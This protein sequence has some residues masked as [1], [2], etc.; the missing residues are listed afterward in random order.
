[1]LHVFPIVSTS[2]AKCILYGDA[3][4]SGVSCYLTGHKFSDTVS[5][6]WFRGPNSLV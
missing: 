1:M 4:P 3:D 5:I 6:P 2:G